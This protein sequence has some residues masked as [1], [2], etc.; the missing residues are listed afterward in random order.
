ML[1][2]FAKI[3]ELRIREAIERGELENLPGAGKPII[4]ESMLYVPEEDRLYFFL[5]FL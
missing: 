1:E 4:I 5:D 3:A 2:N